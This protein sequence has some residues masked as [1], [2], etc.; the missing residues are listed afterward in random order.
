MLRRIIFKVD[1]NND[2]ATG[3]MRFYY[4]KL[5]IA[6]LN[7]EKHTNKRLVS[8]I[9][10]TFVVNSSNPKYFFFLKRGKMYMKR[11]PNKSVIN[12]WSNI[13]MSGLTTSI[14]LKSKEKLPKALRKNAFDLI[15]DKFKAE[16]I[17]KRKQRVERRK[18]LK[19]ELKRRKE[20]EQV[21]AES[22]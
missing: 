11:N 15:L 10:N 17:N 7:K 3:I 18:Q 9:A 16:N 12:Y 19:K 2:Y 4:K 14:G 5:N 22:Q 8:F 13:L 1:G 20:D 21:E 6:V